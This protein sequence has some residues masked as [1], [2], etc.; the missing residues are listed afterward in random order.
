MLCVS[1]SSVREAVRELWLKRLVDRRQGHG[2]FVTTEGPGREFLGLIH[3][4][5]D[6]TARTLLDVMDYRAVIEPAIAARAAERAGAADVD[7]LRRLLA[8]MEAETSPRRA[9]ELDAAFHHTI[10]AATSN[11]L[12][13]QLVEFSAEWLTST[14]HEALQGRRRRQLSLASHR[15]VLEAVAR[16]DPPAAAAAMEQHIKEVAD[17]VEAQLRG[18]TS[19]E[20]VAGTM[21]APR[22][23]RSPKAI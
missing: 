13:L 1:R 7:A 23:R 2:T 22:G 4:R 16:R 17:F 6:D 19:A 9:A 10:A 15:T 8:E 18:G 3:S 12:F 20:S 14:R 11:P 21:R 5:L